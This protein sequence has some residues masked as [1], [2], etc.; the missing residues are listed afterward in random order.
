MGAE[1]FH[2]DRR[3][4]GRT[5]M[6]KLTVAFHNFPKAPKNVSKG[7]G[8]DTTSR[9]DRRILHVRRHFV[10]DSVTTPRIQL[11][12]RQH[13][14]LQYAKDKAVSD[15]GGNYCALTVT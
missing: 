9:T 12:L 11:L 8:A 10:F 2:S 6:T 15:C 13:T 5:D 4:D 1:L 3:T 7:I 14:V